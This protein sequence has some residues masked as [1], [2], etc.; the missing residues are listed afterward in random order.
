MGRPPVQ[1]MTFSIW[2]SLDDAQA[3]AYRGEPHA[4]AVRRVPSGHPR[5][6]FSAASFY[7]YR[8]EGTWKGADPLARQLL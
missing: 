7:P 3:F 6:R 5:V 2:R 8:S 1:P 4:E